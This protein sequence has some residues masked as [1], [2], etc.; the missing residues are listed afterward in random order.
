MKKMNRINNNHTNNHSNIKNDI[1]KII[2]TKN[3]KY[4]NETKPKKK[5]QVENSSFFF[6]FFVSTKNNVQ[7]INKFF[8]VV[9]FLFSLKNIYFYF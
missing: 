2:R 3:N 6:S 7:Q 8:V 9:H 5:M 1:K 4:A